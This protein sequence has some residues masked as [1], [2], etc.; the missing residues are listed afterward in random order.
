MEQTIPIHPAR[1]SYQMLGALVDQYDQETITVFTDGSGGNFSS[2]KRLPRCG[3]A[4]ICPRAGSNEIALHGARGSLG[5]KQAIPR[6]ELAAI[7]ECLDDL[8][9]NTRIK[10]IML[11]SDCNMAVDSY[12][13]GKCYAQE[14]KC[15]A[16]WVDI[17]EVIDH[18]EQ[19]GVKISMLNVKSHTDNEQVAALQ[20][21]LGNQCADHHAG[22]AVV[23]LPTSEV[24]MIRW[25]DRKQRAIQECMILA[26]HMLP[27]RGRH[28]QEGSTL[29]EG[30]RPSPKKPRSGPAEAQKHV[31]RRRGRMLEC[32]RSGLFLAGCQYRC[33]CRS[34]C[35][36]RTQHIWANAT[37]PSL[38]Y[39]KQWSPSYMGR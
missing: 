27:W 4:W 12:A 33:C 22:L 37:G 20:Q 18:H 26:L 2:D 16:I 39:T 15:G 28:P 1:A 14:T 6:A 24:V 38:G 36:P 3:W 5:G 21:R 32:E 11:Y 29:T 19:K 8:K 30:E 34:R 23:E 25:E 13:K 35:M 31:V 9:Q 17:W 10:E 7:L